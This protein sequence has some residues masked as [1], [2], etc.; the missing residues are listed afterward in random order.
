M[1]EITE[2]KKKRDEDF[3]TYCHEK[4][5][6]LNLLKIERANAV[7]CIIGGSNDEI[8]AVGAKAGNHQKPESLLAYLNTLPKAGPSGICKP[9]MQSAKKHNG[10]CFECSKASHIAKNCPVKTTTHLKP[11]PEIK[12]ETKS[13]SKP[14]KK[15]TF[16][17]RVEH[18][19]TNCF[20]K[21]EEDK[22]K[23]A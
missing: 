3:V 9:S 4:L 6:L 18:M 5:A 13:E 21:K 16:Y 1:I 12:T 17:G 7:S 11:K 23:V 14:E 22:S 10:G 15:C 8:V 2:C 20:K 19:E